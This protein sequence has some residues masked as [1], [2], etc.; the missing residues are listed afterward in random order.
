MQVLVAT[1]SAR[2]NFEKMKM[3]DYEKINMKTNTK[4][5][6]IWK[7]K[8]KIRKYYLVIQNI[9]KLKTDDKIWN[10]VQPVLGI[11]LFNVLI[12]DG[13][14]GSSNTNIAHQ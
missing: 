1:P 11:V 3:Y 6:K 4:Y 12:E 8:R 2:I 14:D 7:R 5:I 9:N 13:E 10:Y